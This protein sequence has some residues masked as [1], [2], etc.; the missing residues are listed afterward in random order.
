MDI[1]Q[2]A[3][4]VKIRIE[5]S[6]PDLAPDRRKDGIGLGHALFLVEEIA[7]GRITGEKAHRWLGW[8]QCVC[9][10]EGIASLMEMKATNHAA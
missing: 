7:V 1:R 6:R 2:A 3:L 5:E 8:A 4:S 9:V 10:Y